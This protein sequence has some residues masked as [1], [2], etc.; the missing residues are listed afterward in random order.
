MKSSRQ[1]LNENESS[2]SKF[3]FSDSGLD[4][5]QKL[6]LG[7]LSKNFDI[8][9]CT[10]VD[11]F[12]PTHLIVKDHTKTVKY[13]K[14]VFYKVTIVSVKWV[15]KWM[16]Y[17]PPKLVPIDDYVLRKGSKE[18]DSQNFTQN[19][20]FKDMKFVF[21]TWLNKVP[22]LKGLNLS[23]FV[24]SLGGETFRTLTTAFRELE[25]TSD[26]HTLYYVSDG[27][28]TRSNLPKALNNKIN[29]INVHYRW[30]INC[31]CEN[32]ILEPTCESS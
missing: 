6:L 11:S 7:T 27:Q 5:K 10:D 25:D 12:F 8:E 3:S 20:L 17:K 4:E 13:I 30:V 2:F 14:A 28:D 24:I 19:S 1:K 29:I 31:V 26:M 16:S 23:H 22:T 9:R 18:S 15:K 21:S 32:K